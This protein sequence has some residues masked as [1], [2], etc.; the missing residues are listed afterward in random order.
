MFAEHLIRAN[1]HA[2]TFALAVR[3]KTVNIG[4]R[5][6]SKAQCA[7]YK[8]ALRNTFSTTVVIGLDFRITGDLVF[9]T[10]IN[11]AISRVS[12]DWRMGWPSSIA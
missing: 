2:G 12:S 3:S 4:A 1:P 10:I 5:A 6:P 7:D 9:R 8:G 11:G